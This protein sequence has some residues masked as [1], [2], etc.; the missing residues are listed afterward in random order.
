MKCCKLT[1]QNGSAPD[2]QG[3]STDKSYGTKHSVK[4]TDMHIEKTGCDGLIGCAADG[5][6]LHIMFLKHAVFRNIIEHQACWRPLREGLSTRGTKQTRTAPDMFT[7]QE[8]S[9]C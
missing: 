1:P 8:L 2:H 4:T 7:A 9:A 5:E 3:E 6:A